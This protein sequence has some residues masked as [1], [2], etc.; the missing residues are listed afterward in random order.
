MDCR[1]ILGMG[2]LALV[3][4][5]FA[6]GAEAQ[7]EPPPEVE[8]SP[9]AA[10]SA[11]PSAVARASYGATDHAGV[12]HHYGVG[13]L[14]VLPVPGGGSST[15]VP[16][17]GGRY[18]LRDELGLEAGVGLNFGSN[19]SRALL[20]VHAG[21]PYVLATASHFA[22]E[23]IPEADIGFAA[24]K[25]QDFSFWLH[26]GARVGAEIQFGFI[27]IPQLALQGTVG[28]GMWVT[29]D[30]FRLETT[31]QRSPWDIFT[32]GVAALYYF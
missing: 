6:A 13:L 7:F 1:K 5:L 25:D 29:D 3:N 15:D 19:P 14:G 11:E 20:G 30:E 9:R 10:A 24:Q 17:I 2:V 21:V 26:V 22:F 28:A 12:V 18:W 31:A 27:G 23:V 16:V 8:R 32:G 4:S